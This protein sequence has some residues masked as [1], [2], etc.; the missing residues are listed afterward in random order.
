[1]TPPLAAVSP[2]A[3]GTTSSCLTNPKSAIF[4]TPSGRDQDIGGLQITMDQAQFVGMLDGHGKLCH[5][6]D[7][8]GGRLRDTGRSL[9]QCAAFDQFQHQVRTIVHDAIVVYLHDIRVPQ[10]RHGGRLRLK[11]RAL[12]TV[13]KVGIPQEL[14]G[15]RPPETDLPCVEYNPHAPVSDSVD[16]LIAWHLRVRG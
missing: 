4:R 8:L 15:H 3:P 11:T 6:V 1:M 16:H 2:A 10:P 13:G 7:A 9:G 5:I 12:I 14:Q